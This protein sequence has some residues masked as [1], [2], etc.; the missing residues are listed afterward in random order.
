VTEEALNNLRPQ[1]LSLAYRITGSRSDAEDIVQET[2]MRWLKADRSA[3][4]SPRAFLT[5]IATRLSLNHLRNRRAKRED[6][7]GDWLPEPFDTRTDERDARL[8]A[9]SFGF[10]TLLERLTPLQRAVFILRGAFDLDYV[11]IAAI[12]GRD[13]TAC[14]KIF[15]RA[16]AAVIVARPLKAVPES[17][18]DALLAK[19]LD[20][21]ESGDI[22]ELASML[23]DDVIMRGDGGPAS[24]GLKKPL[25]GRHAVAQFIVASRALLPDG[26]TLSLERLNGVAAALFRARGVCVLAILIECTQ[27]LEIGR[28]FAIAN[29]DKLKA[30][31]PS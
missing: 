5:T 30:I 15:S 23:A 7:R 24:P 29:P 22:T 17:M 28:V 18:H 25:R 26:A 12:V 14:R 9:I 21:T 20:A 10:L 3:I 19:F 4:R 11:E 8:E 13:Q 1:L 31:G 16:K 6:Y 2:G 27:K